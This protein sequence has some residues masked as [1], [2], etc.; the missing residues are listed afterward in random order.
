MRPSTRWSTADVSVRR[1][2]PR[3]G[4][5]SVEVLR[6]AGFSAAEVDRM[7]S[8]G[9]TVDGRAAPGL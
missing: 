5:Q 4:E 6:E 7:L 3:V 9:V 2:A 1:H 8:S